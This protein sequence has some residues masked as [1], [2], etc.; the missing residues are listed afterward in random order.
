MID[1]ILE[2]W[3]ALLFISAVFLT[4]LILTIRAAWQSGYRSAINDLKAT[5]NRR[6]WFQTLVRL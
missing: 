6:M 3:L 1:F 5:H 2:N 4:V